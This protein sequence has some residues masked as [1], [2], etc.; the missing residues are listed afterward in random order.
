M[1][2]R[3]RRPRWRELALTLGAV[4]GV[5]CIVLSLASTVL[6][7]HVL[8]FRSGSMTPTI[9]AGG[10]ALARSVPADDL[11]VGQIVS[12]LDAKGVRITHRIVRIDHIDGQTELVLKGDAN[13]Q[14]DA[15][16]Y[17]V[18]SADRVFWHANR[19][20][21]VVNALGSRG[22]LVAGALLAAALV[23]LG[24]AGSGAGPRGGGP[25]ARGRRRGDRRGSRR[26]E[27]RAG[28]GAARRAGPRAATVVAAVLAAGGVAAAPATA[29]FGDTAT[30]NS[31]SIATTTIPTTT[32]SCGAIGVA[33]VTFNWTAVTGATNYTLYYNGGAS[34]TTTTGTTATVVSLISNSTAWVV[35]NQNFG[36]TTWSSAK[37]NTRSYTVAVVSLCA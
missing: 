36:S 4:L 19:L 25:G 17:P 33:S 1:S 28:E 20:G 11:R 13:Q 8:V 27:R 23:Y 31:G 37:S 16:P 15:Q 3:G 26:A 18:S 21:F 12:V 24:F 9:D 29:T 5:V 34:S 22:A 2:D 14:P 7:I 35:V 10:A 30:V 32:L 6:G